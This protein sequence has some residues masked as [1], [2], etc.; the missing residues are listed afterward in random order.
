MLTALKL[1]NHVELS[2]AELRPFAQQLSPF[3]DYSKSFPEAKELAKPE[4]PRV[5]TQPRSHVYGSRTSVENAGSGGRRGPVNALEIRPLR[6]MFEK[7]WRS[8]VQNNRRAVV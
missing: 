4:V 6:K 1:T 2:A 8:A 3:G 5:G 7:S